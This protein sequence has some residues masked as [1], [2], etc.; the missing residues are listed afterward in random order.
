MSVILYSQ[1]TKSSQPAG[2]GCKASKNP[3]VPSGST[4][5]A[6]CQTCPHAARGKNGG[7]ISCNLDKKNIVD[8]VQSVTISCP[9]GR[10]AAGANST[11]WAGLTW[12][13]V[14]EPLRWL[15]THA[16]RRNV[17][18]D[19]CGCIEAVKGSTF[20]SC[21]EPWF[22]GV[23]QLRNHYGNFLAEFSDVVKGTTA[24]FAK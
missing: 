19:G 6:M 3:S 12:S 16:K 5:A 1:P 14:P 21:L 11:S 18:L 17:V 23:S 7:A 20:G 24:Y 13:G 10:F 22:E 9:I 4:K 15:V 2:C 8:I